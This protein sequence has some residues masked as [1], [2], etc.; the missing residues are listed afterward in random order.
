MSKKKE[1]LEG[2]FR[3][4][5]KG[6]GFVEFEDNELE[7]VFIPPKSVNGALNGDKV[8]IS[9]YKQKEG[10]RKAEAKIIKIIKREKET[11]V[12]IFQKS[13]NFGF[14]VP[15]DKKFLTDIFISK[16]KCKEAKN[17]DKVIVKILKYPE[18]GKNA[19]GE[20][21]EILGNVDTAGVD[22]LSII[23]EYGLPNTF[24]EDV[25][26]EVK[27]VPQ[28]VEEFEYAKRRNLTEEM[29]FTI[30]GEDAKDLDDA[31][32]VKRL[33][34]GN[35]ILDVHIADV[36]HYVKEGSA[37]DREAILRGT[38]VYMFDRVIP[39]LPFELSNGICSL[40]AGEDRLA[41]SCT[42]EIDKKGVVVSSDVYKS[43]IRVTKRMSYTNVNKILNNLD[44]EVTKEY[45]E[46]IDCFK[47]MEEL[48]IILKERRL[49][50]GYLNLDIPESK[51]ILDSTG[52]CIEVKK[53][54]LTFANEIIEQFMLTANETIAEKFYWLEA[55]FIYRVHEEPDIDKIK[56]TNKFLFNIGYKIKASKDNIKPKSFAEVL[57][58]IK[59]TEY[60]K[61][62]STLILRTLKVA[63]YEAE[64][65]GHFGIASSYYCHFTS[66]IR[67]YPDLFI[68]RVISEYI[69]KGY[70]LSEDRL[71]DLTDKSEKYALSSSDA[72]KNATKAERDA[73]D[74]K[75]AEYMEDKIGFEYEGIVSSVTGFGMFV[76]LES[77]VEGIVR[78]ENMGDEY[79]RYDEGNKKLVGE[80]SKLVYKIG[81][82]VKVRVIEA[83]KQLRKVAF[84]IVMNEEDSIVNEEN[85]DSKN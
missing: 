16:K 6:F 9:I 63:R 71:A 83:N 75:K 70:M 66:P 18:N 20:I 50:Q 2:I 24:G 81:D 37:L 84:E 76:E 13:K 58:K 7:D 49:K 19:E 31:I 45:E 55:P 51:L 10:S 22:M 79:F 11:V 48:A 39:M 74:V 59:G 46:Y 5:D 44:E 41:L 72:E 42:M 4:N 57:D 40:N 47:A 52:K 30:D 27:H 3:A 73:E 69:E 67:R 56:E 38:S 23:K 8:R 17:N 54:E 77:T 62:I 64:N 1:K 15:D 65:K 26:E 82:K 36:S 61:V 29:C 33:D 68:H 28:K 12:G 21:L 60:E 43:I 25:K 53:Y 80:R 35:Y 32:F 78:F 34:N 85:V 14:V